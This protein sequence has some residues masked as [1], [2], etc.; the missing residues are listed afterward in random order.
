VAHWIA[1]QPESQGLFSPGLL[2]PEM[3]TSYMSEQAHVYGSSHLK[4]VWSVLNSFCLWLIAQGELEIAPVRGIAL[5]AST[6]PST[7]A[8]TQP[9]RELLAALVER[10]ADI[11]GKA[12]FFLGYAAGCRVREISHLRLEDTSAD[13]HEGRLQVRGP[14]GDERTIA[15]AEEAREP[16][17]AYLASGKRA[18]SA[19]VFTSQRERAKIPHGDLDGWRLRESAIHA[20]FQGLRGSATPK[21]WDLI[22]TLTF[23]DLRR[24]FELRAREAGFTEAELAVYLGR[25]LRPIT[26]E[27]PHPHNGVNAEQLR[28]KLLRPKSREIRNNQ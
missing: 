21:E 3:V 14:R 23:H 1:E 5:P 8:L 9:Q 27:A 7:R 6:P 25:H 28:A 15:L 18:Q 20:W 10:R 17:H 19:Y 12:I 22:G 16:L 26:G 13:K 11:R 24:D 4:R 2:T